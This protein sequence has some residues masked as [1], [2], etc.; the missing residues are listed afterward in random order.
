MNLEFDSLTN[1][2]TGE[3]VPYPKDGKVIGVMWRLAKK[4]NKYGEVYRYKARWVVLGN[5]QEHMLHYFNTWASV[6]HNENFR[7]MVSLVTN[8][9]YIPYQ[10]DITTAFLH[11]DM[12]NTVYVKQVKGYEV[13][14][15]ESWVRKLNK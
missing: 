2:N 9:N 6:G 14:G 12:D 10:F 11:G 8:S 3:L 7:V 15:K 1:Y 5:H 4:C 13:S